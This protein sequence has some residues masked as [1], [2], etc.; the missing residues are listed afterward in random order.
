M[1][2]PS[3]KAKSELNPDCTCSACGSAGKVE[4]CHDCLIRDYCNVTSQKIAWKLHRFSCR[5]QRDNGKKDGL[6]SGIQQPQFCSMEFQ[7]KAWPEHKPISKEFKAVGLPKETDSEIEQ[8]V[9]KLSDQALWL[10]E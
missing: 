9:R 10:D 6:N 1:S 3:A 7:T 8:E 4:T 2:S 5:P